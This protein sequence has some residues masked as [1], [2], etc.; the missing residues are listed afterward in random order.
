[1]STITYVIGDATAPSGD[2]RK[3]IAHVCNDLGRWGRG[4]VLAI[5]RRWTAPSIAYRRPFAGP[6]RPALGDVQ[7]IPVSNTITV[8][9]IIGQHGIRYPDEAAT[10][11][12]P[13][14]YEAVAAGLTKIADQATRQ[15]ASVHM[16]RIGCGLAGGTWERIELLITRG[17]SSRG[18]PVTIY[19]L[20]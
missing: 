6:S 18:I 11:P 8:A 15:S 5:N 9:N 16:P 7:F 14:R 17:L 19:D 20:R 2:G 13:I 3:I 10:T 1:M 12:A 4:F